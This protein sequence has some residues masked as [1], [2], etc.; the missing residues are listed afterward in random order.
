MAILTIFRCY[1][2]CHTDLIPKAE[3]PYI[4]FQFFALALSQISMTEYVGYNELQAEALER[5]PLSE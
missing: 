2:I 4:F 5:T 3:A 1:S